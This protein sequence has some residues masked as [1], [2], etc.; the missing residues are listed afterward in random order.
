MTASD[1]DDDANATSSTGGSSTPGNSKPLAHHVYNTEA[2]NS[3]HYI[4]GTKA[5]RVLARVCSHFISG[6][7]NRLVRLCHSEI[8]FQETTL[9][10]SSHHANRIKCETRK[11]EFQEETLSL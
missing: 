6:G 3:T 7:H 11:I 4:A 8:V 5:A 9:S 1:D 10:R 2:T